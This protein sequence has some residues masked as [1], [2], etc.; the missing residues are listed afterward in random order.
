M[1]R[2]VCLGLC[3]LIAVAGVLILADAPAWAVTQFRREFEMKYVKRGSKEPKDV[4]FAAA[5]REARCYV[6][7]VPGKPQEEH[8]AYGEALSRLLDRERDVRDR[9]KI[10][11]ALDTV[12]KLKVNWLE[13]EAKKGSGEK[14][15][16]AELPLPLPV[17]AESEQQSEKEGEAKIP[18]FGER[19]AAGML[20]VPLPKEDQKKGED[21]DGE[22]AATTVSTQK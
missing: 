22:K 16:E 4:A 19:I 15:G 11:A 6:C 20:P 17:A 21:G 18:T 12:A 7:H 2:L 10:Q 5:V 13:D 3:C 8:N 9:E 1:K 14:A